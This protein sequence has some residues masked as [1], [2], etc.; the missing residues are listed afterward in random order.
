MH[1]ASASSPEEDCAFRA[2]PSSTRFRRRHHR[3]AHCAGMD[4]PGSGGCPTSRPTG[5]HGRRRHGPAGWP[6]KG[7]T[8]TPSPV[9]TVGDVVTEALLQTR[10]PPAHLPPRKPPSPGLTLLVHVARQRFRCQPPRHGSIF[11]SE[12]AGRCVGLLPDRH[13]RRLWIGRDPRSRTTVICLEPQL[14]SDHAPMGTT[15]TSYTFNSFTPSTGL[16]HGN[17]KAIV[18]RRP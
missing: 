10:R 17:G 4:D 2:T 15:K 16:T 1:L 5:D 7:A 9:R 12:Q 8:A 3:P 11:A 13:R 18:G 14:A 6:W